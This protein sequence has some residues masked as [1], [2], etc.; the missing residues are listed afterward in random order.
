MEFLYFIKDKS[1]GSRGVRSLLVEKRMPASFIPTITAKF[2]YHCS[3]W[4]TGFETSNKPL[5]THVTTLNAAR[6]AAAAANSSFLTTPVRLFPPFFLS[7]SFPLIQHIVA[8]IHNPTKPL[9]PCSLKTTPRSAPQQ[10]RQQLHH[11]IYLG[12]RWSGK[13]ERSPGRRVILCYRKSGWER[14]H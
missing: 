2:N 13:R 5:V 11:I 1:R 8:K 4:P 14:R 3:L 9:P 6:K 7:L 10:P 12:R